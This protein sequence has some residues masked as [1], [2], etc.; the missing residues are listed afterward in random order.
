MKLKELTFPSH[1][2]LT[3]KDFFSDV[4]TEIPLSTTLISTANQRINTRRW[5]TDDRLKES[6]TFK[7]F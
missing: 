7:K 2:S 4:L 6:S 5:K 3:Y 1:R